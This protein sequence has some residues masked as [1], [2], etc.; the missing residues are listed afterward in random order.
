MGD[1][2]LAG[3]IMMFRV[4]YLDQGVERILFR[5]HILTDCWN[6]VL[7]RKKCFV[8]AIS[9]Q[10][11]QYVVTDSLDRKYNEKIDTTLGSRRHA[12]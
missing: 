4:V 7:A 2:T 8:P 3:A 5:S 10:A 6:F 12:C 9:Q 1:L 11:A